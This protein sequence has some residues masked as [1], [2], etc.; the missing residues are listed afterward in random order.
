MI[1]NDQ[2]TWNLLLDVTEKIVDEEKEKYVCFQKSD[3]I[4]HT[5]TL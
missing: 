4:K 2:T 5:K 1:G 3:I